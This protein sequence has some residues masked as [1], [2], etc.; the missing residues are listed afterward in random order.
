MLVVSAS[1]AAFAITAN[2]LFADG[3]RLF[4]DDLYWAAL[5]RYR[6]ANDAGLDTPLLHYNMG[7]THYKAKQHIRARKS[8]LK[9]SRSTR[10]EV[11]SHYNLGL[12]AWASGNTN[13]ALKWFR[14]ARDQE[15]NARIRALAIEAMRRIRSENRQQRRS[16]MLAQEK[17][18]K[19]ALFRFDLRARVG[20]GVDSNVFRSPS[21]PYIDLSSPN[22]P[23]IVPDVQEGF[24]VPVSL[25]AKYSVQSF[26]HESFFAA[27]RFG[28]R[29]Y[30][31]A[32]LTNANEYLH[33][34]SFG[35]E[36]ERHE[37]N[38][39]RRIYSA[40]TVAQHDEVFFDRDTGTGREVN[41]IDIEDRFNYLRYGPEFLFRQSYKRLSLGARGKAQ[42]WN[43]EDTEEVPEYDHEYFLFGLN[44]QYRFTRTSLLRVSGDVYKRKFG[45]RPSF[46]LDGSQPLGNTPVEYDYIELGIRARQRV[47]RSLWFSLDYIRTD[48]DDRHVGYNNYVRDSY[49]A[50]LHWRIGSRFDLEASA[51]Y[52]IYDYENAFAF[53][54]PAAARKKLERGMGKGVARFYLTPHLTLVAEY[55]YEDVRS[56]DARIA[57]D[58]SRIG[59]SLRWEN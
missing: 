31:D 50:E 3:N 42:I 43:Y 15:R 2:E 48:R 52:Q 38:R 28:G 4:R 51:V 10:L 26:E 11:L 27:Y 12:N 41:A 36:Y 39:T 33:Q 49:G 23:L 1:T 54:N 40:F 18:R 45:D 20:A 46:E 24:F 37:E 9:A 57:Y 8:L 30:Q 7:V 35:S 13:E 19:K 25:S 53:Q 44:A 34:L 21:Q 58:R 32:A 6:Q 16:V 55:R 14:R 17:Q 56:N 5:L 29:F 59:L 47:T 22:R